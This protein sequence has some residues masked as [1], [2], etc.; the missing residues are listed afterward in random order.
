MLSRPAWLLL[1]LMLPATVLAV[2]GISLWMPV[3]AWPLLPTFDATDLPAVVVTYSLLPRIAT[4]L[5]AGAALGLAGGLAQVALRNPL[6]APGTL[7]VSAG[8]ALAL[9]VATLYAPALLGIFGREVV[10]F[11]GGAAGIGLVMLLTLRSRLDP[12]TVALA[13]LAV[14]LYA[15]SVA[16]VLAVLHTRQLAG[17]F[18][19]SAGT[20]TQL[21][22]DGSRSLLLAFA[23]GSSMTALLARPLAML[24][25]PDTM[26]QGLGVPVGVVRGAALTLSVGLTAA[27]VGQVGVIGFVG[28]AAP[29]LARLGGRGRRMLLWSPLLG[30]GLLLLTDQVVQLISG[31]DGALLPTGAFSALLGVPLLLWLLPRVAANTTGPAEVAPGRLSVR[32]APALLALAVL[33]LGVT[34][35]ALCIGRT[36]EGW[37]WSAG[38]VGQRAPRVAAAGIAG[39]VLA[40][41]GTVLQRV[42]GNPMASPEVLGLGTGA[43]AG[44]GV[45]L[46]LGLTG[47][48]ARFGFGAAGAGGMLLLL[49]RFG[50]GDATRIVLAGVAVSAGAEAITALLLASGDPRAEM[51]LLWLSGSTY[52]IEAAA[53]WWSCVWLVVGLSVCLVALRW[54]DILPLGAAVATALGVP[55]TLARGSMLWLAALLTALGALLAG[56]LSFIGLVAPHV[57]QL[58]GLKRAGAQLAGAGLGGATIM[59]TA[60]WLGRTV[61]FP[62]EIPAGLLAALLGGP[63]LLLTLARIRP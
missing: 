53:I 18:V 9:S 23:V 11:A 51:V 16:G 52:G 57:A 29:V 46:W 39:V 4:A 43:I 15:G 26:A 1:G 50:R 48:L 42:L 54:L 33:L 59:I 13:G 55:M 56:P 58:V 63:V 30:A 6:A 28:L 25:L 17:L 7:G 2:H 35:I 27:V 49:L 5:L 62:S 40:A 31:R 8:A 45:A 60:D 21:G 14:G 12:A 38:L 24:D 10:A 32:A 22:W 37:A 36:A 19:W 20:L 34:I 47:F 3:K 44:G 41:A 61:L